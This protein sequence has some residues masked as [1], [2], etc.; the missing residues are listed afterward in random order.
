MIPRAPR[1]SNLRHPRFR[2]RYRRTCPPRAAQ[3]TADFCTVLHSRLS[4]TT[5]KADLVALGD[6]AV[7]SGRGWLVHAVHAALQREG[8]CDG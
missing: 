6:W 3:G 5:R 2:R 4:T 8:L 1:R 7:T